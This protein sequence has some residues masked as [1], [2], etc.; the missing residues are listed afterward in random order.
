HV[1]QKPR[2]SPNA[3]FAI[4]P[5]PPI[6]MRWPWGDQ[7]PDSALGGGTVAIQ[8]FPVPGRTS[9]K[10]SDREHDSARDQPAAEGDEHL[11]EGSNRGS[12]LSTSGCRSFRS[13]GRDPESHAGGNGKTGKPSGVSGYGR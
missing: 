2:F 3:G 12:S 11:L 9:G 13:M 1:P 7:L 4:R 6:L 10:R 8:L 5:S